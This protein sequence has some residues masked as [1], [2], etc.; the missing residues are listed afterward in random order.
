MIKKMI[1]VC[2]TICLVVGVGVSSV[3]ALNCGGGGF[4][5]YYDYGTWLPYDDVEASL[6]CNPSF[7]QDGSLN[8]IY[9]N[10][11]SAKVKIYYTE[12]GVAKNKSGSATGTNK[13]S[14]STGKVKVPGVDVAD[15]VA[16]NGSIKCT[17]SGCTGSN[18][19]DCEIYP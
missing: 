11:C 10:S 6:T 8:K 4:D 12:N 9:K 18:T 16:Y 17:F 2:A 5:R 15:R 1:S 7:H 19:Y 3:L 13:S 14:L